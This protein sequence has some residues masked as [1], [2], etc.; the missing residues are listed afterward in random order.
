MGVAVILLTLSIRL[1]LFPLTL[2]STR[3]KKERRAIEEAIQEAKKTFHN[4]PER[5]KQEI[6]STFKSNRRIVI[7]EGINFL[8][9]MMIFFI[10]YRIFS[11]GLLGADLHLL[12]NFMPSVELPFN[13]MFLGQYDLTHTN[14]KLNIIQSLSIATLEIL[15][16]IDSP[17]PVTRKDMV[18]YVII[19]PT[20][21]FV[22]FMFLPAGKKLFVITTL[23]F[24]I[25]YTL[26]RMINRKIQELL[27][28]W[29]NLGTKPS[30][31][32]DSQKPL[33]S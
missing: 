28:K 27:T 20:A 13:L 33:T 29:E 15:S 18:R 23:W 19:L 9:Q 31:S 25:I 2:A 7:S 6:R 11:T 12:Y 3:T 16:L 1:L 14:T 10:L 30:N 21:S 26:I 32:T 5:L 17:F 4:R 8:I 24:S 22:I